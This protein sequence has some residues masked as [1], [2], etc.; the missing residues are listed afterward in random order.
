MPRASWPW[1]AGSV[2]H[3]WCR[4]AIG[5]SALLFAMFSAWLPSHAAA[6]A[7][8]AA[9]SNEPKDVRFIL[10]PATRNGH[11]VAGIL[12]GQQ[13]LGSLPGMFAS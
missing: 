7:L 9:I 3:R 10:M 5:R 4:I 11:Y 8:P 12:A 1:F 2:P 13:G 6:E